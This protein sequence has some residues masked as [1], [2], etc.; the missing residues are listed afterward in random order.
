MKAYIDKLLKE[1]TLIANIEISPS[2]SFRCYSGIGIGDV[3]IVANG[4]TGFKT[5][6][7]YISIG[8]QEIRGLSNEQIQEIYDL[9][10]SNKRLNRRAK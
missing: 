5:G 4:F 8:G 10:I 6:F 9:V 1:D 3:D 2:E 7:Y